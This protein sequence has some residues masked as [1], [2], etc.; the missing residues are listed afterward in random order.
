MKRVDAV[1]TINNNIPREVAIIT[2]TGLISRELFGIEDSSRN[3]YMTGSMGLASSLGLG[4]AISCPNK[5][6]VVLEGDCSLLMN[7]GSLATVGYFR[8]KNLIHIIL[9][10]RA[11]AS[12][13]EEESISEGVNFDKIARLIGYNKAL[14]VLNVKQL[15]ASLACALREK[16]P[17]FILVKIELG[18][19]RDLPRPLNLK[20]T[21]EK[22]KKFLLS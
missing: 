1:K 5:K 12:C 7:F 21:T 18:G 16:G 8:P 11:Y 4:V 20:K 10:N 22:F 19:S 13:S 6:I 9:D 3:F 2:S 15:E 14:K 17:F